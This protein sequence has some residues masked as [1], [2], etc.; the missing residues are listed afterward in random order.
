MVEVR[1]LVSWG[2]GLYLLYV[3]GVVCWRVRRRVR[4]RTVGGRLEVRRR[5]RSV[6]GLEWGR[7][8]RV[9]QGDGVT[10]RGRDQISH[11]TSLGLSHTLHDLSLSLEVLQG[12][13]QQ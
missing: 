10:S 2:R 13:A 11:Q 6:A 9:F 1:K 7:Y 5:R 8:G 12:D 3:E 4:G